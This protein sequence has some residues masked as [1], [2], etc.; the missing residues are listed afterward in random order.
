MRAYFPSHLHL[1]RKLLAATVAAC[2]GAAAHANPLAPQVVAGQAQFSQQGNVFS[3]TNAPNTII[4]WQSFSIQAGEI[5][6]FIQQ[7]GDS[8]VLN[9]IVGQDPSKILGALQSN[10]KVYLIN[11]NGVLFGK[12]ARIDVNGLVASSLAISNSDFLAGKNHFSGEGA[13]KVVNQ[14]S[15]TTPGG[16]QVYL[17]GASVENSGV[18]TTP[19]GEVVLAAGKSVQL[20]DSAN[21]DVHVVLSAPA[22]QALNLGQ[23][24]AAGGK[25]GIYGALV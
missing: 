5:T 11:P 13:G 4:N 1:K 6:R 20:V 25:V 10:G 3:I 22:D 17:I 16:G 24:L 14:G 9:R 23:V 2:F 7:G 18:I 12:D 8:K 19:Q 21:P 15:I